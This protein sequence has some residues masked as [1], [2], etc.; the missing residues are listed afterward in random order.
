MFVGVAANVV[1]F[2]KALICAN[3][4]TGFSY[5]FQLQG[6]LINFNLV[7]ND[8][9]VV[10]S[11]PGVAELNYFFVSP[12]LDSKVTIYF[13]WKLVIDAGKIGY[14]LYA[15]MAND[16]LNELSMGFLMDGNVN[17]NGLNSY[18]LVA[19]TNGTMNI[20][21]LCTP[22]VLSPPPLF[23]RIVA[24]ANY[25]PP[26]STSLTKTPYGQQSTYLVTSTPGLLGAKFYTY[27]FEYSV[28]VTTAG[29]FSM[30]L[31]NDSDDP[32]AYCV[33]TVTPDRTNNQFKI[34]F[35][36][37]QVPFGQDRYISFT[38]W[39]N[40]WIT[41]ISWEREGAITSNVSCVVQ[42][43]E[44]PSISTMFDFQDHGLNFSER[45]A[46]FI[47]SSEA[48]FSILNPFAM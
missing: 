40:Q 20:Y 16:S 22:R 39:N 23:D 2:S 25:L 24:P 5:K 15:H 7:V 6:S 29:E 3:L 4:S 43:G 35:S 34:S 27:I 32:Y 38:D 30:L 1:D 19:E 46:G 18:R 14:E 44:E 10:I 11:R 47:F 33:V 13:S 9:N 42:C 17:L 41:K 21:A 28:Y 12:I 31:F 48:Q 8:T 37:G 26:D 45:G 36:I